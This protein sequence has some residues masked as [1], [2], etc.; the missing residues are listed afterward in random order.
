MVRN[1]PPS[2]S[3]GHR[4]E[5]RSLKAVYEPPFI[6]MGL[7]DALQNS[8]ILDG[9]IK[10]LGIQSAVTK[11]PVKLADTIQPVLEVTPDKFIDVVAS[12]VV[13]GTIVTTPTNRDFF[14]TNAWISATNELDTSTSGTITVTLESGATA[15]IASVH[16]SSANETNEFSASAA[17]CNLNL[18]IPIKLKRG[19]VITFTSDTIDARGGIMGYTED[20]Q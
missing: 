17:V 9:I 19:T 4:K 11:L 2:Y 13:T 20:I 14:L 3:R 12:A 16:V 1:Q 5:M 10:K 8:K 18:N 6:L 7:T 15:I